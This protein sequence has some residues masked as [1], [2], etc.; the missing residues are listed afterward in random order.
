MDYTK[1]KLFLT[2]ATSQKTDETGVFGIELGLGNIFNS[3]EY[4]Q[5]G[6]KSKSMINVYKYV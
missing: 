5:T 6:Y 4:I 3:K 2:P 1:Q